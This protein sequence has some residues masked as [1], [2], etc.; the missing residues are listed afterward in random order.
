MTRRDS[1]DKVGVP[2][3]P[4]QLLVS[5]AGST[6]T[7]GSFQSQAWR[8]AGGSAARWPPGS[9]L[10]D[11]LL[12]KALAEDGLGGRKLGPLC[13]LLCIPGCLALLGLPTDPP[14]GVPFSPI[15]Q[16]GSPSGV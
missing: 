5:L 11:R 3:L 12:R 4:G 9:G 13:L 6:Q 7:E 2:T 10:G 1:G 8:P 16:S 15:P 14:G